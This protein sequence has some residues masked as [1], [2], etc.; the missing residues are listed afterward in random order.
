[1]TYESKIQ[2]EIFILNSFTDKGMLWRIWRWTL[3]K[4]KSKSLI[5]LC[6]N[7]VNKYLSCLVWTLLIFYK[8]CDQKARC[9]GAEDVTWLSGY[10]FTLLRSFF[11][12]FPLRGWNVPARALSPPPLGCMKNSPGLPIRV[13]LNQ[14]AGVTVATCLTLLSLGI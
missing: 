12:S 6:H 4:C 5:P 1:M 2:D 10:S 13:S 3:L 7:E 14:G 11:L 9:G 8:I